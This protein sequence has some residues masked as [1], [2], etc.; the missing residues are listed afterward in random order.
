MTP[1]AHG[2]AVKSSSLS[3]LRGFSFF[4]LCDFTFFSIV[5]SRGQQEKGEKRSSTPFPFHHH[6]SVCKC[7]VQETIFL[8]RP[9][10]YCLSFLESVP[11]SHERFWKLYQFSWPYFSRTSDWTTLKS[12]QVAYWEGRVMAHDVFLVIRMH[13]LQDCIKN[14]FVFWGALKGGLITL[15]HYRYRLI[16]RHLGY[17]N[18]RMWEKN[19]L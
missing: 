13:Q 1:A 4:V 12:T 19:V 2:K 11:L 14:G 15:P 9:P 16:G 7:Q 5:W 8:C 18:A 10:Q 3:I 17:R 6:H